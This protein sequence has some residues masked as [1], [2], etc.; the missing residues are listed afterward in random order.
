[1]VETGRSRAF[2]EGFI[3][4]TATAA[5][6]I[7]G[8]N[9]NNDW[10]GFE[11]TPGSGCGESRADARDRWNRWKEDLDLEARLGLGSY[12][13]S[14]EWSR[15][16]PAQDEWSRASLDHYRRV[17]AG[18]R[19]RGVLPV[20]TFSHFTN[21]KWLADRGGWE[22]ADA[23]ERFARFCA[24]TAAAVGD[25]VGIGCTLNEP[26]IVSLMGYMAGV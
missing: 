18:C 26:N 10:W 19:E 5:H 17:V 6:Q 14:V 25:L 15:V 3:W 12:R 23:P 1:M 24:T 11:H 8:G 4:G 9:V 16:E 7:E 20:V 22:A 2:P 21:P 13:F